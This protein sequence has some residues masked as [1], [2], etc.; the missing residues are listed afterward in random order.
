MTSPFPSPSCHTGAQL[1]YNNSLGR[2]PQV[3]SDTLGT[4]G[5][6]VNCTYELNLQIIINSRSISYNHVQL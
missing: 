3:V 5:G 1:K 4:M 2:P 6:H